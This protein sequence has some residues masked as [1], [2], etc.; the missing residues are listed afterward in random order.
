MPFAETYRD[1]EI[2]KPGEVSQKEQDK[3]N[4]TYPWNLKNDTNE[5]SYETETDSHS[6]RGQTC[7]CQDWESGLADENYYMCDE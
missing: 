2:I 6:E 3:Q 4:N 1:L 7:G 5:P